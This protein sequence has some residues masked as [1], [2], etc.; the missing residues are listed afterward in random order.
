MNYAAQLTQRAKELETQA[1]RNEALGQTSVAA[2]LLQSAAQCR[3]LAEEQN[4]KTKS[5]NGL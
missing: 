2:T 3:K 1:K 4:A 5:R